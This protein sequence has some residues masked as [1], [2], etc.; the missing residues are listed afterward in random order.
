MNKEEYLFLKKYIDDSLSDALHNM[1][2]PKQVELSLYD[3]LQ[4]EMRLINGQQMLPQKVFRSFVELL[5]A[6]LGSIQIENAATMDNLYG[7]Y[8]N[9]KIW[10][11]IGAE[12]QSQ[13]GSAQDMEEAER[14]MLS[15][16]STFLDNE[17]ADDAPF[18]LFFVRCAHRDVDAN[19]VYAYFCNSVTDYH[20]NVRFYEYLISG[21][22]YYIRW[23]NGSW[24]WNER[25]TAL[26]A[27]T[28]AS[29]LASLSASVNDVKGLGTL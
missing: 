15:E 19:V 11:E 26:T 12:I 27:Q 4:N 21:A 23:S 25:G 22:G 7:A 18:Y 9:T 8:E 20:G 24:Q 1:S 6:H 16:I 10:Q 14:D 13:F 2:V 29:L 5:A 17:G 28:L 3:F